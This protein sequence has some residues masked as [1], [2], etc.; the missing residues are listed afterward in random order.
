MITSLLAIL[1]G[2]GFGVYMWWRRRQGFMGPL[3]G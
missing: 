1:G 2:I 3:G